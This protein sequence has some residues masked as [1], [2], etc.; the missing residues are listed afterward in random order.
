VLTRFANRPLRYTTRK[1]AS[2]GSE[3]LPIRILATVSDR[4]ASGGGTSRLALVVAAYAACLLGPRAD[5]FAVSD[6]TL[7]RLR[8]Q[9]ARSADDASTTIE[10]LLSLE[11]IF[12]RILPQMPTFRNEVLR[13]ALSLWRGDVALTLAAS[14]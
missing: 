8:G 10:Q 12:G 5:E 4:L 3:K 9:P 6:P 11:A 14:C 7:D 1:V 13:H 2:D